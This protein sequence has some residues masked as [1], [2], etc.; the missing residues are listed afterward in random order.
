M[1]LL[2]ISKSNQTSEWENY[3]KKEIP[4]LNFLVW[5][6]DI[7]SPDEIEYALVWNPPAHALSKFRNLKAILSLGAGVDS[8][9]VEKKLPQNTP[10][11]RLVDHCLTKGMTE[12]IVY[13]TL[14]HHRHM[15]EYSNMMEKRV[16]RQAKIWEDFLF[17]CDIH[18]IH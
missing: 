14:F 5:P 9:L 4:N 11:I 8:L 16:W 1:N 10:I 12:Y 6:K 18:V 3:L 7:K 2:F 15:N 17:Y 13:W